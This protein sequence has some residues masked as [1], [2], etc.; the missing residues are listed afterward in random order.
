MR[1]GPGCCCINS[2]LGQSGPTSTFCNC[3]VQRLFLQTV[4]ARER[5][6]SKF[7]LAQTAIHVECIEI[8]P[9]TT[10]T[11]PASQLSSRD[12][13]TNVYLLYPPSSQRHIL[14]TSTRAG[15]AWKL[16]F[17]KCC[18]YCHQRCS[19]RSRRQLQRKFS[20]VSFVPYCKQTLC[21]ILQKLF[22]CNELP[23]TSGESF[24]TNQFFVTY[25]AVHEFQGD[26]FS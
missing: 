15:Y 23:K 4:H 5:G 20:T 21:R 1:S 10:I 14:D 24:E 2:D 12:K 25:T 9:Q 26:N 13:Y 6:Y 19:I 16:S 8:H 17:V 22:S 18:I 3:R 11:R 7:F